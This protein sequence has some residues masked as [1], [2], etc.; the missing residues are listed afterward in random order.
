LYKNPARPF[1]PIIDASKPT[2]DIYSREGHFGKLAG[3]EEVMQ[4]RKSQYKSLH[5][6]TVHDFRLEFTMVI[7][8]RIS[9]R[10]IMNFGF[11]TMDFNH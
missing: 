5:A 6:P 11:L 8:R 4:G 2:W 3:E 1:F 9:D 7:Y 10:K